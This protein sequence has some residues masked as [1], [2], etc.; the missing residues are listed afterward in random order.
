MDELLINV[1]GEEL[2]I[3]EAGLRAVL[4]RV[5]VTGEGAR[6]PNVG[7]PLVLEVEEAARLLATR[8]GEAGLRLGYALGRVA[9]AAGAAGEAG[10][11]ASAVA[12]GDSDSGG[13]AGSE[14]PAAGGGSSA[15]VWPVG[16][17]K[18][19][20]TEGLAI[21]VAVSILRSGLNMPATEV[22]IATVA[23]VFV[24]LNADAVAKAVE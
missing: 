9:A 12:G 2:A 14:H 8:R 7:C 11:A 23:R 24:A 6:V 22:V 3:A 19:P 4:E 16:A 17:A 1:G 15:K 18:P 20:R 13:S 21:D 10:R 5:R